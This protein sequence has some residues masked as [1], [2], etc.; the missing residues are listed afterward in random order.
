M[1][2]IK[3]V[4]IQKQK[5]TNTYLSPFLMQYSD[6]VLEEYGTEYFRFKVCDIHAFTG[7]YAFDQMFD[8]N[9]D[10]KDA[11]FVDLYEQYSPIFISANKG[12]MIF[13]ANNFTQNI[14]TIGGVINI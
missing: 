5:P 14:G 7:K 4:L 6:Y 1:A 11:D 2:Y 3:D 8:P 10:F 12:P 9:A 13:I